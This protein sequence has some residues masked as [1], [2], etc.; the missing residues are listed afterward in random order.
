MSSCR[1]PVTMSELL[2][3]MKICKDV[4]Q[5]HAGKEGDNKTLTKKEL[6]DLLREQFGIVSVG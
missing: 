4:F 6:S 3:A 5:R 2:S 1:H